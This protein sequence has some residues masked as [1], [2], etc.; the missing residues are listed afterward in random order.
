MI[1]NP[2]VILSIKP[3]HTQ[4]EETHYELKCDVIDA[5]P[6]QNLKVTWYKNNQIFANNVSSETTRAPVNESFTLRFSISKG[7]NNTKFRC[8]AKLDFGAVKQ[9]N[10]VVS[11]EHNVSAL[12]K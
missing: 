10:P 6:A 2:K 3:E 9:L 8:E 4:G 5:A 11:Q 1:D 12:C 7:E